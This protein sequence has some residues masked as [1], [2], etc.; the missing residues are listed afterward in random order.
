MDKEK[1]YPDIQSERVSGIKWDRS[2]ILDLIEFTRNSSTSYGIT[3]ILDNFLDKK[4]I[5]YEGNK[6]R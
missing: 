1:T 6:I 4:S 2:L 3:A 5:N